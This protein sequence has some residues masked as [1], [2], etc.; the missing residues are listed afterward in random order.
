MRAYKFS[1][2]VIIAYIIL[3]QRYSG[4][5]FQVQ[6]LQVPKPNN[7]SGGM[8][9]LVPEYTWSGEH[10]LRQSKITQHIMVNMESLGVI[11]EEQGDANLCH[12][13]QGIGFHHF[14]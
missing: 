6:T 8:R 5:R 4:V 9:T 2:S 1:V 11:L 7:A 10:Y 12:Q 3:T 13:H 14:F